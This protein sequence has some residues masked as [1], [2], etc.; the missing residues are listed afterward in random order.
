MK[1]LPPAFPNTWDRVYQSIRSF[2]VVATF[3]FSQVPA[4]RYP[5]S[6]HTFSPDASCIVYELKEGSFLARLGLWLLIQSS[7]KTPSG[8]WLLLWVENL[9]P[10]TVPLSRG[11][12]CCCLKPEQH[13]F[14]KPGRLWDARWKPKVDVRKVADGVTTL[15]RMSVLPAEAG[16]FRFSS[17][18]VFSGLRFQSLSHYVSVTFIAVA[19]HHDRC[20]I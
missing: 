17:T 3:L 9:H 19:K 2:C 8:H 1:P 6:L 18:K 4:P 20:N 14:L 13:C 15:R 16:T 5:G 7:P 11:K 12:P 10:S